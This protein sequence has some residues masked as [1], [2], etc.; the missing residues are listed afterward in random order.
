MMQ[1]AGGGRLLRGGENSV[2]IRGGDM[3]PPYRPARRVG[4]W[5]GQGPGCFWF[6]SEE[7]SK[8]AG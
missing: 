8:V 5:V 3:R 7:R 4:T 6:L 1:E 2:C